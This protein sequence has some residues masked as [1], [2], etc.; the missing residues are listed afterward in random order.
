MHEE[1]DVQLLRDYA[2]DGNEAAFRELVT[3]YTDLVYSAALRQVYSP[4]LAGDIAQSVFTDLARKAQPVAKKLQD[5]GSLA[6]WLHRGTRYAALSQL[7]DTRCRLAN[8]RQAMEQLLTNSESAPDWEHIRSVLDEA[9][10]SLAE[11]DREALLLRYFKNHDFRAVGLALGVSDDAA[12]KRVSRAVESLREFFLK[13]GIAVGASGLVAVIAANAVQAAPAGLAVTISTAAVLV[14]GAVST[15]TVIAATKTIAM[16]TLQKTFA[17]ATLAA[18][19]GTGVYQAHQASN[20]RQQVQT[21]Q[22]ERD[23]AAERLGA[24]SAKLSLRLPAPPMQVTA[25][26]ATP[27]NALVGVL[28]LTNLH[29]QF[30]DKPKLTAM[31]VE[32]YLKANGR[33][34]SS[35]L[36][37]YRTSG[38]P[39]LLQEA[40]QKYP[41]DPQVDFEAVFNKDLSPEERR[42]WLNAFEKSAP[43]NA[44]ANYLS[45]LNYFKGG[46]TD[47]AVQELIA[48]NGKARFQDYL[49]NRIQDDE[50]AYL[51]AGYSMVD[52]ETAAVFW[53][54][55]LPQPSELRQFVHN[56]SDLATSYR[57][58]G[59][60]TSAQAALQ[61]IADLGQRYENGSPG[62]GLVS[63]NIG[64]SIERFALG[65]MAPNSPYGGNGQTIQ[66][67]LNQLD[68]QLAAHSALTQQ[69]VPLQQTMSDQDWISY[70]D[71]IKASGEEVAWRWL[72]KGS[73]LEK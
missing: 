70:C 36:S 2:E 61:T 41:D 49:P 62:Q 45:A 56:I 68:Q 44:L 21:L 26:A 15:S 19:I 52:A 42:Q 51:S 48:A 20:L 40:M 34:A 72:L 12:Q 11:E 59:D 9:L 3:R 60:A 17:A 30:E 67:R 33:K 43:D 22:G 18:A 54:A 71:R 29:T 64:I 35:L 32:A 46:K 4:D 58:A 31:Q 23:H 24:L 55:S 1:S 66:D 47:Q 13:R 14:G 16:T 39:T 28:Q 63:Q 27:T 38:D 8:E 69:G 57:Q 6:G 65:A 5:K 7:R 37:A 73:V 50:E 10:D 25:Q 53:E